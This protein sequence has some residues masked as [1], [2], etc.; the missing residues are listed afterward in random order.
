MSKNP[1]GNAA[2]ALCYVALVATVMYYGPKVVHPV[3]SVL[4]PI[5][6]LSLFV[7]SA[8]VMGYL[9]LYQPLQL[10]FDS[11]KKEALALFL[12]T[13]G[14]FGIITVLLFGV[15]FLLPQT[16]ENPPEDSTSGGSM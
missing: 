16:T 1:I 6:F 9:F 8:A 12:Q 2:A 5:A 3:E 4:L 14:S 10:Y 11:Q 7:L 13:V 15:M